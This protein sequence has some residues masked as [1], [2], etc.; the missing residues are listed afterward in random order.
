MI[1]PRTRFFFPKQGRPICNDIMASPFPQK[2]PEQA[3]DKPKLSPKTTRKQNH[4][5][6][7]EDKDGP[8][9][10][11]H[12]H[13]A[14]PKNADASE[15]PDEPTHPTPAT[16]T[17]ATASSS[18][19]SHREKDLRATSMA[20]QPLSVAGRTVMTKTDEANGPADEIPSIKTKAAINTLSNYEIRRSERAAK[21]EPEFGGLENDRCFSTKQFAKAPVAQ[22]WQGSSFGGQ[23]RP[24]HVNADIQIVSNDDDGGD[25]VQKQ[26]ATGLA[27]N[28][29]EKSAIPTA[30]A[31]TSTLRSASTSESTGNQACSFSS[32]F[33]AAAM[34]SPAEAK[35]QTKDNWD[36]MP[37]NGSNKS[38]AALTFP[39]DCIADNV[40]NTLRSKTTAGQAISTIARS[41][42]PVNR[43]TYSGTHS[44]QR[45]ADLGSNDSQAGVS[46]T[47]RNLLKRKS[48]SP[49]APPA[50]PATCYIAS[51][52]QNTQDHFTK[53]SAPSDAAAA[54]A[55]D[56][57][58]DDSATTSYNQ[59]ATR[60]A[61]L[62]ATTSATDHTAAGRGM[63][64]HV[65][66]S[67]RASSTNNNSPRKGAT[68][69]A[70]NMSKDLDFDY[71][72]V[73]IH[74]GSDA[75]AETLNSSTGR[76]TRSHPLSE[77]RAE[78]FP[79]LRCQAGS[80]IFAETPRSDTYINNDGLAKATLMGFCIGD[81]I[82]SRRPTRAAAAKGRTRMRL[83]AGCLDAGSGDTDTDEEAYWNL[84]RERQ[85]PTQIGFKPSLKHGDPLR[86]VLWDV[87]VDEGNSVFKS[88][89]GRE[90][91]KIL[92]RKN[93]AG[94][95]NPH[96]PDRVRA[97]KDKYAQRVMR[98]MEQWP[99]S[100][101]RGAQ[102]TEILMKKKMREMVS[103]AEMKNRLEE[104]AK[105]QTA[106]S[107]HKQANKNYDELVHGNDPTVN[108]SENV[109][110]QEEVHEEGP[111]DEEEHDGNT[112]RI[113]PDIPRSFHE[114]FRLRQAAASQPLSSKGN[115][116]RLHPPLSNDRA[117]LAADRGLS[118][119]SNQ[120]LL[121]GPNQDFSFG[122]D[123]PLYNVND[124]PPSINEGA[125][126]EAAHTVDF[127]WEQLGATYVL[128]VGETLS[129]ICARE[130]YARK[131]VER[132]IDEKDRIEGAETLLNMYH[133]P[134]AIQAPFRIHDFDY[135]NLV[136]SGHIGG[137]Q[138]GVPTQPPQPRGSYQ[139]A[140]KEGETWDEYNDRITDM[141]TN[142]LGLQLEPLPPPGEC[143]PP[144]TG[145]WPALPG[146]LTGLFHPLDLARS[147]TRGP[148]GAGCE[149]Y[150][151]S[152]YSRCS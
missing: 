144:L 58:R 33:L 108:S 44:H 111:A 114:D 21:I 60:A 147:F 43:T 90:I 63:R 137:T 125:A 24:V 110:V 151:C 145:L 15:P 127:P 23:A 56:F 2:V 142:H 107:K 149:C 81:S 55:K 9:T 75:G 129:E 66:S 39:S 72:D 67:K 122:T 109:V 123:Q 105:E 96:T 131:T 91:E 102:D 115:F 146:W 69:A 65:A 133:S 3:R 95:S 99:T 76:V 93:I 29:A 40:R 59:P 38:S 46:L 89:S 71:V 73:P 62:E 1:Q 5:E 117:S 42:S 19:S 124:L 135:H 78:R 128:T 70:G 22:G 98:A 47:Y 97:Q 106:R 118:S 126:R 34:S 18:S 101:A 68:I 57:L 27:V 138:A 77:R 74:H 113:H 37:F 134:R 132:L 87:L 104:D 130:K 50:S 10:G 112:D 88:K 82:S 13:R 52:L 6:D 64:P 25:V 116:T 49:V 140:A 136:A 150:G 86:K 31:K 83:M 11:P 85:M 26:K 35:A 30:I 141:M 36:V 103:E 54:A 48:T 84:V 143:F 53:N 12:Q 45:S 28:F 7:G 80:S 20:S 92:A 94:V 100:D 139:R 121:F 41:S 4:D 32:P 119:R 17:A 148:S 16:T 8:N 61:E 14:P 79:E 120:A 51:S 152:R